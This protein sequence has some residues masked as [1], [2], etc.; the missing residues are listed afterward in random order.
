MK[1]AG[2]KQ[3]YHD[4]SSAP[5]GRGMRISRGLQH[6]DPEADASETDTEL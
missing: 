2:E 4:N 6:A 5:E 3:H 1:V